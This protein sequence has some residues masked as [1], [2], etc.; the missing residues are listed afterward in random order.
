MGAGLAPEERRPHRCAGQDQ[1]PITNHQSRRS[2]PGGARI[3]DLAFPLAVVLHVD[4]D[5]VPSARLRQP[6]VL[7]LRT[8][9]GRERHARQGRAARSEPREDPGA[10]GVRQERVRPVPGRDRQERAPVGGD[11]GPGRV[12]GVGRLRRPGRRARRRRARAARAAAGQGAAHRH[13]FRRL[14][15]LRAAA[16]EPS[17]KPTARWAS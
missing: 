1:S 16:E 9:C 12:P 5:R 4:E 7:R 6:G 15:G 10:Q 2:A 3:V 14:L 8:V 17:P 11:G 13:G